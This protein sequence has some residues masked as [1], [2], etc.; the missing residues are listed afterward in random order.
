MRGLASVREEGSVTRREDLGLTFVHAPQPLHY[1]SLFSWSAGTDVVV[2]MYSGNRYEVECKYTQFVVLHSRPV[3]PRVNLAP[4]A[5]V[6]RP[7][8]AAGNH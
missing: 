6:R 2:A 3:W 5:E 1:Y 8:Y 7:H 4:L